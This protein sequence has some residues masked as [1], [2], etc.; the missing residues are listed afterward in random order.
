V[1]FN[2]LAAEKNLVKEGTSSELRK[3]L[4]RMSK[5][6]KRQSS[7][8]ALCPPPFFLM[9]YVLGVITG[10]IIVSCIN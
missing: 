10:T 2:A 7:A 3:I 8:T 6:L 5:P 1:E 4:Q 9:K